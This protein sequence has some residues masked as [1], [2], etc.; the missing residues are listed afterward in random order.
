MLIESNVCHATV[1]G[2]EAKTLGQ[3]PWGGGVRSE[4]YSTP[5]ICGKVKV[6]GK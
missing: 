1:Q 3:L 2:P 6:G 5:K 4:D